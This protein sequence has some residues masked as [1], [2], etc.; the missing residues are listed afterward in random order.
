MSAG[1]VGQVRPVDA[2]VS[3]LVDRVRSEIES[4]ASRTFAEWKPVSYATQVVAGTNYFVKIY[5][6]NGEY[7]HVRIWR[8]IQQKLNVSSVETGKTEVDAFP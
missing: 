7:I 8:N 1:G 4:K 3:A 2:E 6:G 5:V